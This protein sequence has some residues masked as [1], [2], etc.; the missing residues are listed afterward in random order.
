MTDAVES[1]E[2][3]LAIVI[4]VSQLDRDIGCFPHL[5]ACLHGTFCFH[6]S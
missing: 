3:V 4:H 5:E 6:E 2:L 1:L